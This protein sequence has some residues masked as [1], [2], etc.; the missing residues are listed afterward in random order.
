MRVT[1]SMLVSNFL[2][3]MNNNMENMKTIQQQMTSGKEVQ[4]PS[5]DPFKAARVMQLNTDI[6][7]NTQYNNNIKDTSNWL[8]TSDTALGQINS[9][10]Q[11]VNELI[12]SSGNASYGPD[13]KKSIKDEI[14]QNIGQLSQILNT[15]FDGKYIFG[16]TRGTTKPVDSQKDP[17]TGNS[18]IS[19]YNKN[20]GL[21]DPKS[22]DTNDINQMNMIKG[23]LSVEIS[24]GV[25]MDYNV[26]AGDV[27]Q[28]TNENGQASNLMDALKK[29]TNHL[30]GNNDDGTA[31]DPNA[32]SKLTGSDMQN[33]KDAMTNLLK[34]RSEVGAKQN[35]MDSAQTKNESE[36]TNLTQILS[37]TEDIDIAQKTMDYATMQ[38]VYMA[39]LQ[40]S[41]KIIQPSLMDYLK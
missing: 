15:N 9:V 36:N 7:S 35:R 24:Q 41:A 37:Q 38:N 20:G 2:S 13:E 26:S 14:N 17:A 10:L 39:S 21:I 25:T 40:T 32:Y 31:S 1:N 5:D 3:D 12:V 33:M 18:I 27:L 8:S 34:I 22:T 29:I 23:S 16:G 4:K 30:D 28:F 11:R 19:Y 6:N